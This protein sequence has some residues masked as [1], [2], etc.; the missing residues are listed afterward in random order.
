M[1]SLTRACN[2]GQTTRDSSGLSSKL[3]VSSRSSAGSVLGREQDLL[4]EESRMNR[5][6]HVFSDFLGCLA[7]V[8]VVLA[9]LSGPQWL[10]ADGPPNNQPRRP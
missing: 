4:Q 8:L 3:A 6:L 10:W 1:A 2:S 7:V 5:V 9:G